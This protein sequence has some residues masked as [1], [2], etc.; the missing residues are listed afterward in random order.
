MQPRPHPK[1][2]DP[3][4]HKKF[5]DPYVGPNGLTYSVEIWYD[6]TRAEQYTMS[7]EQLLKWFCE[8]GGLT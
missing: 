1:G 8:A 5:S 3:S 2:A 6:N 7:V 4:I